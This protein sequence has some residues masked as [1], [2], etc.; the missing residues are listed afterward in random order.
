[1]FSSS[2]GPSPWF[3]R[4]S[5]G[6]PND[7][8]PT[9]R[10]S[11][12]AGSLFS[13]ETK[14]R[15]SPRPPSPFR[16]PER[17]LRA[18]FFPRLAP[19]R[20]RVVVL[21]ARPQHAASPG[22]EPGTPPDADASRP[23]SAETLGTD[24][25]GSSSRRDQSVPGPGRAGSAGEGPVSRRTPAFRSAPRAFGISPVTSPVTSPSPASPASPAASRAPPAPAAMFLT[26]GAIA[27]TSPAAPAARPR[28][29]SVRTGKR[30]R[31]VLNARNVFAR[32]PSGAASERRN[33]A[34]AAAV[35][36]PPRRFRP[37]ARTPT[38]PEGS[39][40]S[41]A[42]RAPGA[43]GAAALSARALPSFP[44]SGNS[45]FP[46]FGHPSRVRRRERVL[47]RCIHRGTREPPSRGRDGRT[48]LRLEGSAAAARARGVRGEHEPVH[49]LYLVLARQ[50]QER[51]TT[52]SAAR[53]SRSRPPPGR[54]P[55][56]QR[57]PG[58]RRAEN[59]PRAGRRRA[60]SAVSRRSRR[61]QTRGRLR[62]TPSRAGV[63]I[64]RA[65]AVRAEQAAPR[66]SGRRRVS[67]QKWARSRSRRASSVLARRAPRAARPRALGAQGARGA[68]AACIVSDFRARLALWGRPE[69]RARIISRR[70]FRRAANEK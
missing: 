65:L 43:F 31:A 34:V 14:S 56:E 61:P 27:A 50:R 70:N 33:V 41:D 10:S 63:R 1:M 60:P 29:S 40:V 51:A 21:G 6:G 18:P 36:T 32:S 13:P 59:A 35:R 48:R 62:G 47:L 69:N 23:R 4:D 16:P 68:L 17:R 45:S 25:S 12:F 22:L 49:H 30:K 24:A 39:G 9:R 57:G 19:P 52:R 3:M 20:R 42:G 46:S 7:N 55:L 58:R 66:A 54:P 28:P 15:A 2:T 44:S 11:R 53:R 38:W 37:H 8:P 26:S 5:V 64:G 67:S